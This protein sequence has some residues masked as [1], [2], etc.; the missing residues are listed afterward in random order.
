MVDLGTVVS[1][2]TNR[3]GEPESACLYE[4]T[5]ARRGSILGAYG[6]DLLYGA[7]VC[8]ELQFGEYCHSVGNTV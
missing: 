3:K 8:L 2:R 6:L 4:K 5:V 7:V 1:M